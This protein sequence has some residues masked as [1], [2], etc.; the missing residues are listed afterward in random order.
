MPKLNLS[1]M[2]LALAAA[3]V[4][5]VADKPAQADDFYKGKKMTFIVGFGVG[6][7]Y[8]A[9]SRLISAHMGR[10]LPGNPS[11][12]VQNM[13]GAGSVRATNHLYAKSKQDGTVIGMIDQS[14]QAFE[15]LGRKG[16]TAEVSK[17]NWLGRLVSN[18]AVLFSWHTSPIKKIEDALTTEFVVSATGSASRLNWTIMNNVIGTKIKMI[19]GYKGTGES[20][21]AMQRGEIMGLSRPWTALKAKQAKWIKEGKIRLLLQTGAEKNADLANV[22]RMV[23]MAKNDAD[24]RL[25]NFFAGPSEVGRSVVAPP[26]V[27]A[28]RVALLREAFWKAIHDPQFKAD[29]ERT[30]LALEPLRGEDLQKLVAASRDVD[31]ELLARAKKIAAS[32]P[33]SKKSKKKKKK[34]T[35]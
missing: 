11:I 28:A 29:L 16:L 8:N 15:L 5:G 13:P 17:F 30:K 22:P 14:I 12:V 24:R 31:P 20:L 35:N 27:P 21:L 7:S 26:G 23:D 2:T 32:A 19:T 10:F 25:L 34:A 33:K 3:V 4:G 6:G 18:S 9:Y 1:V